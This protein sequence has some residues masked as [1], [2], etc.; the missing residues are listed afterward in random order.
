MGIALSP[1]GAKP[2]DGAQAR[3]ETLQVSTPKVESSQERDGLRAMLE[4]K[5]D[6]ASKE[7]E[8]AKD[9]GEQTRLLDLISK[10]VETLE[11]LRKLT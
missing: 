4:Q 9:V 2:P 5:L 10:Y 3:K 1:E 8:A 7:L 11:K 6:A